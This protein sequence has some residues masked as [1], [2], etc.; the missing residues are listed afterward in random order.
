MK[1]FITLALGSKLEIFGLSIPRHK[2]G[3]YLYLISVLGMAKLYP[4]IFKLQADTVEIFVQI[5]L[6][7]GDLEVG[8]VEVW[9]EARLW[10][11]DISVSA[12]HFLPFYQL[13]E[14]FHFMHKVMWKHAILFFVCQEKTS[15]PQAF[16]LINSTN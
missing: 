15:E 6:D 16:E 14:L 2:V 7:L 12:S 10:F 13:V 9:I 11:W 5:L 3:R 8:V 4:L 1:S